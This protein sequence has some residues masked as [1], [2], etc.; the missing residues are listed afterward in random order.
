MR[1]MYILTILL[2]AVIAIGFLL[3]SNDENSLNI[4]FLN[5]YGIIVKSEPEDFEK[6]TIPSEFDDVYE[7][8]NRL[9][10]E[11]G[12][13]LTD[14]KGSTGYRYTYR[15]LNFPGNVS[16]EI[17]ADVICIDGCRVAGDIMSREIFGF[18]KPLNYLLKF[19]ND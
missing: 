10:T 7:E 17:Y 1:K 6:I 9:Q 15:I 18:M 2:I 4:K 5:S 19:S 12:L 14:Y 13:D 3:F 16:E 11:C 8:Y